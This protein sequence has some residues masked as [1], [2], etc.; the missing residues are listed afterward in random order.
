MVGDVVNNK[1]LTV[2]SGA[3]EPHPAMSN[4]ENTIL[5]A[6]HD[7]YAHAGPSRKDVAAGKVPQRNDFTYR[8]EL[9]AYLAHVK[10]APKAAI[11]ILF[12]EVAA[13]VSYYLI[14][15]GY[16]P[17]KATILD[18][19]DYVHLGNFTGGNHQQRFD[20]LT[21]EYEETQAIN[22]AVKGGIA[23]TKDNMN[24]KMLSR[25]TRAQAKKGQIK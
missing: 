8:G 4:D 19:F 24:W 12:T 22:V 3:D 17:Q 6:V 25:G 11:P 9:N 18:G 1:N 7:Y 15:G 20:E 5:R 2:Y 16:A 23:L 13:Q 21:R 14:T 10:I